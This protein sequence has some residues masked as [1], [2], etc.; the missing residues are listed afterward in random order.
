MRLRAL[1]SFLLAVLFAIALNLP[2][3]TAKPLGDTEFLAVISRVV[4]L[5]KAGKYDEAIP[6]ARE[7]VAGTKARFGESSI[8]HAT[9]LHY[10]ANLFRLT[11][12]FAEAEPLYRS[13]LN[14]QEKS[15]G[16][17]HP[18]V[19]KTLNDL[20]V[21]LQEGFANYEDSE[22]LKRRAL[23]I[24]ERSLGPN[25]PQVA[26]A[27]INL[28][29]VLEDTNRLAEAE[30]LVRRALAINEKSFGPDHQDVAFVLDNLANLLEVTNRLDEA[31]PLFRRALKIDEKSLGADH[32][33]VAIRLNNLAQ[34]LQATNRLAEAE[35]LMRR[36]LVIDEKSLGPGD[37]RVAVDLNNLALLLQD[38][39]RA[40]EAEPLYRRA[41]AIDE[42]SFGPHH[43][44]V[45]IRLNNLAT[46]L[47]E[48]NRLAEAEPL[49]RRA[50]AIWERSFG[51]DHP[52]V[53]KGLNNLADLIENQGR[54]PEAIALRKRAKPFMTGAR[55]SY[56]GIR[57][58]VLAQNTG[59]LRAY[60]R[61]LYHEGAS[62]F[63]SRAEGFELAQWALQNDAADALSAMATRFAMG[64]Q[65]LGKLV[66]EQQDLL[67]A[68]EAAYRS[69]DAA[70]GKADTGG[71]ESARAK[72]ADIEAKLAE[73]QAT[74]RQAFPDYADFANPKPLPLTD[75][76]ALLG[77]GDA[78]VLFLS[79]RRFS[80]IPEETIV[81]ALTN[82][83]A[84]WVRIRG[85]LRGFAEARRDAA[86]RPR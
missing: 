39:N 6:L 11:N 82:K 8:D 54:W 85:G 66:R 78:L 37:P 49:M 13:A 25:D 22:R 12:R 68:R 43:P 3:A 70:A 40:A 56:G 59:N 83:E 77:E 65:E 32:P 24:Y 27:L 29:R 10:L 67:V 4:A 52:D 84:R 71:S 47:S 14:I 46:L 1:R 50:L 81:F 74:L 7:F 58:A 18:D 45:A 28:A 42:K 36:A 35:P 17:D 60:V 2:P 55:S 57:K 75:A 80:K 53:V 15:L 34:L 30:P 23:K 72:I 20:A 41:L 48:A 5:Y 79:L 61:A 69:L 76:Q 86:L 62:D 16:P 73:K 26:T 38:T 33:K 63:I 21:L 31:E 44:M 9:A 19:A 64:G 51:P